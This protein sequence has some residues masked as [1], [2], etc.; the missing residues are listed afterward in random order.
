[1]RKPIAVLGSYHHKFVSI[2]VVAV[3]TARSSSVR[4][5]F[6]HGE[7]RWNGVAL[8]NFNF[9]VIVVVAVIEG[10]AAEHAALFLFDAALLVAGSSGKQPLRRRRR[11]LV[12]AVAVGR[13]SRRSSCGN[14]SIVV[15]LVVRGRRQVD[16]NDVLRR[17]G[18]VCCVAL[19]C[20]ALRT[21]VQIT[22]R[23]AGGRLVQRKYIWRETGNGATSQTGGV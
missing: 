18:C 14:F 4:R 2:I 1:M 22:G 11:A 10:V 15:F 6:F 23:G 13:S 21:G 7:I 12:V 19:R 3:G 5:R 8:E 17:H 20:A 9:V 16:A